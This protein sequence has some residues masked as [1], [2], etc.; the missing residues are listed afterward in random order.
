MA[1]EVPELPA[2]IHNEVSALAGAEI[3]EALL[4]RVA[5]GIVTRVASAGFPDQATAL[6][7]RMGRAMYEL[8]L[9]IATEEEV[10]AMGMLLD[11]A[12]QPSAP[13]S[14]ITCSAPISGRCRHSP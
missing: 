4:S 7:R 8:L 13:S 2:V 12:V 14:P 1:P 9:L 6:L 5:E 3:D 11:A 10:R